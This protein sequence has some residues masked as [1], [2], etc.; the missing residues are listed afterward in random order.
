VLFSPLLLVS[1]WYKIFDSNIWTLTYR[2]MKVM[3]NNIP[4]AIP[5]PAK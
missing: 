3:E 5:A 2:E 4:P 1:G